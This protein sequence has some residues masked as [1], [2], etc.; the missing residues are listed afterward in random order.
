M[1]LLLI[2]SSFNFKLIMT[3][4]LPTVSYLTVFDKYILS[5]LFYLVILCVWHA[6]IG[7]RL[8][9]FPDNNRR[10]AIDFVALYTIAVIY[11]GFHTAYIPYFLSKLMRQT[12]VEKEAKE[13]AEEKERAKEEKEKALDLVE[14][15]P[16][17]NEISKVPRSL[18]INRMSISQQGANPRNPN[19]P[20]LMNLG[21]MPNTQR[22]GA[23]PRTPT[24]NPPQPQMGSTTPRMDSRK[25]IA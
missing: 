5:A 22:P 16:L 9:L 17:V 7:S 21:N 3:S 2:L 24:N 8:F 18:P 25:S 6:L 12:Q 11:I 20:P 13:K 14:L 19:V 1:I 4:R 10:I 15:K 23:P